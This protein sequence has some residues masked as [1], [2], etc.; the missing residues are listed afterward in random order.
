[1][2]EL[3]FDKLKLIDFEIK[4]PNYKL[5]SKTNPPRKIY[6]IRYLFQPE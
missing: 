6:K 5:T 4:Y 1:M 2:I 3:T